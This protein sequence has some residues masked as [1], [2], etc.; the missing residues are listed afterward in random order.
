MKPTHLSALIPLSA[1]LQPLGGGHADTH[2]T[3][4]LNPD[5]NFGKERIANV[6][7]AE[8]HDCRFIVPFSNAHKST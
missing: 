3:A 6:L 4:L 7:P 2:E 8:N 5:M 1:R